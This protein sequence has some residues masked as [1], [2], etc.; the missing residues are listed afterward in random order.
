M[1]RLSFYF[2]SLTDK[3]AINPG[4]G[5]ARLSLYTFSFLLS[6]DVHKSVR[7]HTTFTS[8]GKDSKIGDAS[9]GALSSH[10]VARLRK[11]AIYAQSESHTHDVSITNN[12]PIRRFTVLQSLS[13]FPPKPYWC[14]CDV[15]NPQFKTCSVTRPSHHRSLPKLPA[16]HH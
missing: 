8:G 7:L 13:I 1:P 15:H 11:L 16:C 12:L 2:S 9:P 4:V 5:N 6:V 14:C 10:A 3:L